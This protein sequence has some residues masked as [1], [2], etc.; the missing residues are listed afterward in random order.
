MDAQYIVIQ[1]SQSAIALPVASH[2]VALDA[3]YSRTFSGVLGGSGL[4]MTYYTLAVVVY[5]S[6]EIVHTKRKLHYCILKSL[7]LPTPTRTTG[8]SRDSVDLY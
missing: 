3:S 2:T 6:Y 5:F 8:R 1:F 7:S 4:S